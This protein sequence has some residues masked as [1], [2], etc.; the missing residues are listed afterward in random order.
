MTKNSEVVLLNPLEQSRAKEKGVGKLKMA[1]WYDPEVAFDRAFGE[2]LTEVFR[3]VGCN[4]Y[5][6]QGHEM[7]PEGILPGSDVRYATQKMFESADLVHVVVSRASLNGQHRLY[8]P[9]MIGAYEASQNRMPENIFIVPIKLDDT[10]LPNMF[11]G[12]TSLDLYANDFKGSGDM[13]LRTWQAAARQK[14][15]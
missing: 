14:G 8:T 13:L 3:A 11:R 4:I 9:G 6:D 12:L 5:D 2:K 7:T 10:P 15:Y 1:I